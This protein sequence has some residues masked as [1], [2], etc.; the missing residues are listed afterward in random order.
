ML[1]LQVEFAF[2]KKLNSD[3]SQDIDAESVIGYKNLSALKLFSS[4]SKVKDKNEAKAMFENYLADAGTRSA[5]YWDNTVT[6]GTTIGAGIGYGWCDGCGLKGTFHGN[7]YMPFGVFWTKGTLGL[8]LHV[9]DLGQYTSIKRDE[10]DGESAEF[11]DAILPGMAFFGRMRR[12]PVNFGIDISY[13]SGRNGDAPDDIQLKAFV[14]M[15]IPL[16]NL[17]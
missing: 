14:G 6:L 4:L 13:L 8:Q 5:R 17:K 1:H 2:N 10:D 16:F 7:L 12:Y 15:D 11:E 3:G 9:V